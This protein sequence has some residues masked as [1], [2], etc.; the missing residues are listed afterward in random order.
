[1]AD[2]FFLG[3]PSNI[4]RMFETFHQSPHGDFKPTFYNPFEIKHRRRTSKAQFRVLETAFVENNKPTASLRRQ[5]AARLNMTPR[6]VQVWFQNRRAKCKIG[7]G[8]EDAS[9]EESAPTSPVMTTIDEDSSFSG[10]SFSTPLNG[11]SNTSRSRR[12]AVRNTVLGRR[13]S[14]PDIQT[15]GLLQF[16]GGALPFKEL[17]EAIFGKSYGA[18]MRPSA[19]ASSTHC[20]TAEHLAQTSLNHHNQN[21]QRNHVQPRKNSGCSSNFITSFL[22][23]GLNQG[24]GH[25]GALSSGTSLYDPM[26]SGG[27]VHSAGAP[28]EHA[29]PSLS[30]PGSSPNLAPDDLYHL[31]SAL[32]SG[33]P[34][35]AAAVEA[36]AARLTN[37]LSPMELE[38]LLQNVSD[39]PKK[40]PTLEYF[41]SMSPGDLAGLL[42]PSAGPESSG[43]SVNPMELLSCLPHASEHYLFSGNFAE[44]TI[45]HTFA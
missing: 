41:G 15:Q 37:T 26:I 39:T 4:E 11:M 1:M 10:R 22:N 40:D 29:T 23:L 36:M 38:M 6:A 45:D 43:S 12:A 9:T 14:M 24:Y 34:P 32:Q 30:A 17:H 42:F 27:S 19:P 33:Q 21:L 20:S 7:K 31:Q 18:L 35:N 8:G 2:Y 16:P 25:Y 44:D 13:H 5:L 3:F 28:S